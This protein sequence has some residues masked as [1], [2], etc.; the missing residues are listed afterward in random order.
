MVKV[1]S[2]HLAKTAL[3][4]RDCFASIK[5]TGP[6]KEGLGEILLDDIDKE[7]YNKNSLGNLII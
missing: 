4:S 6:G 5:I 7:G 1:G 3:F 2:L